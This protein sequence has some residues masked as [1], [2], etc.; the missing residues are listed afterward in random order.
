M[1]FAGEAC[2]TY[3]TGV[4]IVALFEIIRNIAAFAG[5]RVKRVGCAYVIIIAVDIVSRAYSA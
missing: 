2:V 3:C 5:D 4:I 1:A